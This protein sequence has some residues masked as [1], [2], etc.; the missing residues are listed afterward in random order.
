MSVVPILKPRE[1]IKIFKNLVGKL[2]G[3]EAVI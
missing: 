3:N 1:V 2:L